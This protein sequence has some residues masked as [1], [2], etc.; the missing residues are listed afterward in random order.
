MN[1]KI[2]FAAVLSMGLVALQSQAGVK[3]DVECTNDWFAVSASSLPAGEISGTV[4]GQGA[5]TSVPSG[6][7]TAT[8][9]DSK[10]ILDTAVAD[11]LVFKPTSSNAV[12]VARIVSRMKVTQSSDLPSTAELVGAKTALCAC[13]NGTGVLKW[14]ALT[15]G[16][17]VEMSNGTPEPGNVYEIVLETDVDAHN[18]RYLVKKDGMSTYTVVSGG[19]IA[20]SALTAQISA[21]GFSGETEINSFYGNAIVGL[22]SE[23]TDVVIPVA[24]TNAPAVKVTKDWIAANMGDNVGTAAGLADAIAKINTKPAGGNDMTYWQ[25]YVLGLT[26]SVPT[27]KPIVQPVQNTSASK[28]AFKLGNVA[29]NAEAGVPVKYRVNSYSDAA[30]S[31]DLQ[32]GTFVGSGETAES[33]G[34]LPT[35]AGV[36]YYKLEIKFGN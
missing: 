8:V 14:F 13:T 17:W 34:E 1:T 18:I 20:D 7:N 33:P 15:S 16:A 31:K 29:V 6:D 11:P 21:I 36:K 35:A 26:P 30:C 19:W 12:P 2:G 32:E 3:Y 24:D 4:T 27:S 28:V 23:S 5:W 22:D 25:S 10:I 9:A